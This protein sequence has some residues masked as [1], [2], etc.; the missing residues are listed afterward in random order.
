MCLMDFCVC[1][2][3]FSELK[4]LQSALAGLAQAEAAA[5]KSLIDSFS[6]WYT[7]N[8]GMSAPNAVGY[9]VSTQI[10]YV[11]MDVTLSAQQQM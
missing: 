9:S 1:C 3:E 8:L 11:Y 4:A 7:A 10:L 5:C 2:S 6:L